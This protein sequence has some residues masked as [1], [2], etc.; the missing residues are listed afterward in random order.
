MNPIVEKIIQLKESHP[1]NIAVQCFDA[2]Y[3]SSLDSGLQQRLLDCMQSGIDNPESEMGCYAC[4]ADD[5]D[6]LRPF[7]AKAISRY[8]GQDSQSRH[9]SDWTIPDG[10]M[11]D[12]AEFGLPPLSLRIRVGRNFAD[13]PLTSAMTQQDRTSL[14]KRMAD[15]FEQLQSNPELAGTYVSLTPGHPNQLTQQEYEKLVADHVMFKAMD[16]DP[17]LISA[18]IAGDWPHGRGCYYTPDHSFI[19]WVG[20][21]DHLRIMCM[22]TGT[23]LKRVLDQ[24]HSALQFIERS[25]ASPFARSQD[26]GTVTT[27][28]TNLGTGMRASV[29]LN[30]PHLTTGGSLDKVKEIAAPLGLGIR[31]MGGEH[32][33]IGPDGTVDVSPRARLYITEGNIVHRL[34]DGIGQL[35][36]AEQNLSSH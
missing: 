2:E 4:Q 6:V 8:H 21:E 26:F 35:I 23:K 18:G 11:L 36:K 5:Y 1:A 3:F 34:Y 30:L 31:G 10:D 14:E 16:A 9:V 17:Y 20:E 13:L 24:L 29:H 19:V 12:I 27:C 22:K 32:T 7:F 28:P 15:V 25:A 33:P